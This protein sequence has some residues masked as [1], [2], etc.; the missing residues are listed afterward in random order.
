MLP[1]VRARNALLGRVSPLP[2]TGTTPS[3][4]A[5]MEWGISVSPWECCTAQYGAALYH[6]SHRNS[7]LE[8]DQFAHQP[9]GGRNVRSRFPYDSN[10][11]QKDQEVL[12]D[13]HLRSDLH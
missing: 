2:L 6:C 8:P 3:W 4:G 12:L 13:R 5:A 7:P 11:L 10:R 9:C 1:M